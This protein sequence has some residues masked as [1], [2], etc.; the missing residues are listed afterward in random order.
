MLAHVVLNI[1]FILSPKHCFYS[2]DTGI[3]QSV[4]RLRHKTKS[5]LKF[6]IR[7]VKCD[8]EGITR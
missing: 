6:I 5:P 8:E 3:P 2:M 4:Y 1:F 7:W